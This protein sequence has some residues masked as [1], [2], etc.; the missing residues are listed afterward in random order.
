MDQRDVGLSQIMKSK[1]F[2]APD[3][4]AGN[5]AGFSL[6]PC[7]AARI[8]VHAADLRKAFPEVMGAKFGVIFAECYP[9]TPIEAIMLNPTGVG[10]TDMIMQTDQELLPR[11]Q[12]LRASLHCIDPLWWITIRT[13]SRGN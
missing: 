7:M 13:P 2:A 9:P 3:D 1:N 6:A 8:G 5:R 4:P 12:R 10:L 11:D